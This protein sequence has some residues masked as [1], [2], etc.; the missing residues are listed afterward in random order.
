A[1]SSSRTPDRS[2]WC[3]TRS[4]PSH[5]PRMPRRPA[6]RP[7]GRRVR[8]RC[9]SWVN[10]CH[11]L[12][13]VREECADGLCGWSWL[14]ACDGR[15][16]GMAKVE[17]PPETVRSARVETA[18]VGAATVEAKSP[19]LSPGACF[20]LGTCFAVLDALTT[21]YGLR[22]AHLPEGNPALRWAFANVGLT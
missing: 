4:S 7:P 13:K 2:S 20:V 19:W 12:L 6:P 22:F 1:P 15:I 5:R 3:W 17:A 10:P 21:W 14:T 16:D 9:A 8:K 18:R 11:R